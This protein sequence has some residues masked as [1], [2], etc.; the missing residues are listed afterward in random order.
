MN[1]LP[2]VIQISDEVMGGTP[3]FRGTRVPVQSLF[4]HLDSDISLEE[5]LYDFPSVSEAQATNL[6]NIAASLVLARAIENAPHSDYVCSPSDYHRI[7][8][9]VSVDAE[10]MSGTPVFQGTR[11]PIQHLLDHLAG[12]EVIAEFLLG[13]PSVSKEQAIAFVRLMAERVLV[14]VSE[15]A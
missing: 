1:T 6:L 7:Q 8:E 15:A 2:D 10:R 4:D 12:N 14:R 3:V 13:Y 9:T 5:F 11:V